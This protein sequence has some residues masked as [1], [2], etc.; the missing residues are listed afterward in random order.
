M[1]IQI[2]TESERGGVGRFVRLWLLLT[3][4]YALIKFAFD[5][6]VFGWIDLRGV[7]VLELAVLPL[8]QSLVFWI[9]TRRIR[10]EPPEP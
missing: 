5:L 1:A 7:A 6:V 8:G 4:A 3:F 10:G 9:V 2:E